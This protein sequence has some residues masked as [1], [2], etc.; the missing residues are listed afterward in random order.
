MDGQR[1]VRFE[2]LRA[3]AF[4]TIRT[5]AH[6]F[7][8]RGSGSFEPAVLNSIADRTGGEVPS[9]LRELWKFAV[10]STVT[11]PAAD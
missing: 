3:S 7:I 6:R 9:R 8:L 1:L 4:K 5:C 11:T 2:T 10:K